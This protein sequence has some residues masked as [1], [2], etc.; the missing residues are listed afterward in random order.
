MLARIKQKLSP[1]Y[2]NLRGWRTDRKIVVIESDDWGS[3]RM[4]SR[5]VYEKCLKAGYRVDTNPYERYDSL[6]SEDD[7]EHLFSLLSSFK[8]LN[9]THPVLTA[10]ILP[11]N[12]DFEKIM[13]SDFEEYHFELVTQ[14]FKKYP[15]HSRCFHIWKEGLANEVFYPQSHGREHL[16]VSMFMN[17]LQ[18]GDEDAMFGFNNGMPGSMP[19]GERNGSNKYVE[20]LWYSDLTDKEEKLSIILEGL[21]MFEELFGYRS[22]TFI[23]PN[24]LWSF[25]YDEVMYN[26]G[27][28]YYQGNRKMKEPQEDGTVKLN[29][30]HIGEKNRH[31]QTYLLRNAIFEPSLFKKNIN[32]PVNHCMNQ[33]KAAFRLNKPAIIC[34]HRIN[35]VGYLSESNRDRGLNLLN[36]L[37]INIQRE[38]PETEFMNS[39]QL[40]GLIEND[41]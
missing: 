27:V 4:P 1:Y 14:T 2:T 21:D 5:D 38:W 26:H 25:D 23:P 13:N 15:K 30:H 17:A 41:D 20:T 40:G 33:I 32:D 16:N 11:A 28:L 7:L 39:Y 22:E 37:L 24:Y 29:S 35:Y 3:I 36:K 9:G 10:N 31:G 34:S 19:H 6:A 12:P 18:R 8:D